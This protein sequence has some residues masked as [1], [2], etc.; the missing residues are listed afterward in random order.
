MVPIDSP[1]VVSYSTSIDPIVVSVTMF[2]TFDVPIRQRVRFKLV[3]VTFKA[4]HSGLPAYVRDDLHDY[5]PTR[6]LWSSAAHLLH[7]QLVLTSV[8][9]RA[10]TVATPTVWNSLSVNTRSAESFASF[11]LRLKSELFASTYAT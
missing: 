9:S 8:A 6:I 1:W 3:A 4:N 11:K 5:Q 7:R 10:F 2:E